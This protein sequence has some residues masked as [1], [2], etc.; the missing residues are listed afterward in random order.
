MKK[1]M[2]IS[3]SNLAN[4]PRVYRQIRLL[5]DKYE[6]STVGFKKNGLENGTFYRVRVEK[7]ILLRVIYWFMLIFKMFEKAYWLRYKKK[8]Y[9]R[10]LK[11]LSNKKFDLIIAHDIN[12]LPLAFRISNGAKILFDAHEYHIGRFND[13]FLWRMILQNRE[14]YFCDK[15]LKHCDKVITVCDSIANEY[16]KNFDIVPEI[17]TNATD[18][19]D[20]KPSQVN[21]KSVKLIYHGRAFSSRKIENVINTM[22]YL[23]ERYSLDLMLVNNHS[24]NEIIYTNKLKCLAKGK[25]INFLKPVLMKEIVK[26]TNKYDIGIFILEPTSESYNFALPNKFFEFIQARLAIAIGPSPEMAKIVKKYDL[27]IVTNDFNPK[28]MAR[29]LNNLTEDKIMYYKNQAYKIAYEMSSA[30]EMEKL[31]DIITKLLQEN[32]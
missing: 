3:L 20:L 21:K 18:Y 7:N 10:L 1:I 30:K 31:D 27:G 24:K 25:K 23:D 11:L 19:V 32:K 6:I 9:N 2:I 5:R 28:T 12:T 15:Y 26:Q 17:I 29:E 16:S 14:K 13:L 8:G 22:K 4:E